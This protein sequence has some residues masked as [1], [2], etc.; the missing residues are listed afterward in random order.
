[1]KLPESAVLEYYFSPLLPLASSLVQMA[2]KITI[3]QKKKKTYVI[4]LY[5]DISLYFNIIS[6]H[7]A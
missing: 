4:F 2:F 5:D 1:M 7:A 6:W 3:F